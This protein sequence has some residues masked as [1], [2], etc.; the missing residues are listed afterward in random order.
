[1]RHTK[2]K[3]MVYSLL[4]ATILLAI[5]ILAWPAKKI[6]ENDIPVKTPVQKLQRQ[7]RRKMISINSYIQPT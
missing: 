6:A 2:K 4:V 1:M 3:K 7:I 5:V